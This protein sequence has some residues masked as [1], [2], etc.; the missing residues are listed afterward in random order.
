M[1][2]ILWWAGL[3]W[4]IR[5]VMPLVLI[6]IS[7]VLLIAG[8]IWPWGWAVGFVLLMFSGRSKSEKNG[9]RF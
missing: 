5:I 9:Y 8:I 7:T 3:P 4:Q 6:A 1:G 2:L